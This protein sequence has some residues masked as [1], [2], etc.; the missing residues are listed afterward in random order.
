MAAAADAFGVS[1]DEAQRSVLYNKF[2]TG[3][4]RRHWSYLPEPERDGLALGS[5]SD[6]QRGL[7][8]RLIAASVSMPGYAKVVSIIAME[9]VRR[10]LTLLDAPGIAHLFNPERYCVRVFGSPGTDPWGWQLAGHHVSL[11]FTVT[12]GRYL[13][14]TPCMLGSVP[15][16]YGTLAP[17]ADDEERG[18]AFVHSLS[19][20]QRAVAVIHHR[21]PPDFVTRMTPRIGRIELP[22]PVFDP[23]PDYR[24]NDA[25]R[26]VLSY[27]RDGPKGVFGVDLDGRQLDALLELVAGFVRRLPAEVADAELRRVLAAGADHLAFAWAGSTVPGERH[28]FRV[29]GPHLLI[30]HDN[31]QGGGNHIHSVWRNPANDFGDDLLAAHYRAEH[32]ASKRSAG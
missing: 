4:A 15:A 2:E 24:I 12:G 27:V 25:E 3:G 21:P 11:N 20:A 10:A 29:Q 13:S 14:P 22:D 7:A 30:E 17:L 6:A 1:L 18:Y 9:H 16:S 23:E 19:P 5:L 26:S 8:H 32:Q 28:Y 31:T